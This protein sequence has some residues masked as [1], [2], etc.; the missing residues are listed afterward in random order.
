MHPGVKIGMKF[1][2]KMLKPQ[3]ENP[4][5][6]RSI[7]RYHVERIIR[8]VNSYTYLLEGETLFTRGTTD[9]S[10]VDF[11]GGPYLE[12]GMSAREASIPDN[13]IIDSLTFVESD[14]KNY[15]IVK[16]TVK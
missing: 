1:L 11:E 12:V 14:K 16:I 10:M 3:K 9:N 5:I 7:S 2:K 6:A 8:K 13:R 4:V 15:A